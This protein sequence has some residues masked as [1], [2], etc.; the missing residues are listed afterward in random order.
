MNSQSIFRAQ[1][2]R[3][4]CTSESG[5]LRQESDDSDVG[6]PRGQEVAQ[7]LL[8]WTPASLGMS[9]SSSPRVAR[10]VRSELK[11]LIEPGQ[12]VGPIEI[13]GTSEMLLKRMLRDMRLIRCAE[14]AIGTWVA[15]DIARTP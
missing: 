4:A 1:S 5:V 11:Q 10:H 7:P 14:E 12:F 15:S 9:D 2:Q 6:F 13:S 8:P 3:G